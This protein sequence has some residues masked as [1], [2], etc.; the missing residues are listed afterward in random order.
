MCTV[1]ALERNLF[2][3]LWSKDFAHEG[4]SVEQNPHEPSTHNGDHAFSILAVSQ[5][6]PPTILCGMYFSPRLKYACVV[7]LSTLL[8][9][10]AGESAY[11]KPSARKPTHRAWTIMHSHLSR[12]ALWMRE[13]LSTSE[14]P[15]HGLAEREM[16]QW[17]QLGITFIALIFRNIKLG[18]AVSGSQEKRMRVLPISGDFNWFQFPTGKIKSRRFESIAA[19][20]E[21]CSG[22]VRLQ[23]AYNSW[24]WLRFN[25][26]VLLDERWLNSLRLAFSICM[27]NARLI[28]KTC[29]SIQMFALPDVSNYWRAFASFVLISPFRN[30]RFCVWEDQAERHV[31]INWKW[32][33]PP[34]LKCIY[35]NP[36]AAILQVLTQIHTW[37]LH[38]YFLVCRSARRCMQAESK[39]R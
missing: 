28:F 30:G 27:H 21:K 32:K 22:Q 35:A 7:S 11:K 19:Q 2:Q 10:I 6:C 3:P 9:P 12:C 34:A 31:P 26:T 25:R 24:S 15:F 14:K 20:F 5:I 39:R 23:C 29:N 37:N 16:L 4:S 17:I 33:I 1:C 36:L 38:K 18:N 13:K 8:L